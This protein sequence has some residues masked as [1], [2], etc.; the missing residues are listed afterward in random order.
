LSLTLLDPV[1]T[2]QWAKNGI[3]LLYGAGNGN[4]ILLE[5]S[6][7]NRKLSHLHTF[8][9]L[10]TGKFLF[11]LILVSCNIKAISISSDSQFAAVG[12][13]QSEYK[14]IILDLWKK[15]PIHELNQL[16]SCKI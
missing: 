9:N 10:F 1:F 5:F 2:V 12:S 3:H 16:H 13:F 8:E 15:K 14:V 7:F 4:V 11:N 6:R